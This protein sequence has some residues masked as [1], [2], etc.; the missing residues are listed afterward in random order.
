MAQTDRLSKFSDTGKTA[1]IFLA[2]FLFILGSLL[3]Y[4]IIRETRRADEAEPAE[5][6]EG[7]RS[8][9]ELISVA[10]LWNAEHGGVYA[11]VTESTP[12]NP[13]LRVPDRDSRSTSGIRYTKVN[14]EQ[15]V[16]VP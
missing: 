3:V 5:L 7:A 15:G 14:P 16:V 10:R 8:F 11:K 2:P 1:I 12:P 13:Y 6:K 4:F 9:Y